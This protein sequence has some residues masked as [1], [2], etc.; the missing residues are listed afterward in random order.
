[1][2][3]YHVVLPSGKAFTYITTEQLDDVPACLFERFQCSPVSVVPLLRPVEIV[4]DQCNE[5]N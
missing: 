1:V 4:I 3:A 2:Q 5:L